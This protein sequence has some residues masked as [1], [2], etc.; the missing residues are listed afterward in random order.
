MFKSDQGF[1]I[2]YRTASAAGPAHST[3]L[4]SARTAEYND[5]DYAAHWIFTD[6]SDTILAIIPDSEVMAILKL[7]TVGPGDANKAE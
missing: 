1:I 3:A 5:V 4:P 7:E 2:Y 6:E